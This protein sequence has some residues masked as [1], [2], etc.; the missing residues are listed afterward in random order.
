M[1]FI[2]SL[3]KRFHN[4]DGPGAN[5]S[6]ALSQDFSAKYSEGTTGLARPRERHWGH[7]EV[8]FA[9]EN[10]VPPRPDRLAGGAFEGGSTGIPPEAKPSEDS[11]VDVSKADDKNTRS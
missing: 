4:K 3:V 5:A 9:M 8:G 2:C 10:G 1:F 7:V 11:H 6:G